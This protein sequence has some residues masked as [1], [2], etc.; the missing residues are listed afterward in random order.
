MHA[1]T[2]VTQLHNNT[3]HS[4]HSNHFN[5]SN[6]SNQY[7]LLSNDPSLEQYQPDRTTTLPAL[8]VEPEHK[9]HKAAAAGQGSRRNIFNKTGKIT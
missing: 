3:N 4:K 1:I 6:Q 8:G 7:N 2:K 5:H 9:T